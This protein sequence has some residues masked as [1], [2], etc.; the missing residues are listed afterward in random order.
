MKTQKDIKKLQ[1]MGDSKLEINWAQGKLEIQNV[2]LANIVRD[3]KLAFLSFE[4]L[5]FHHVLREL[6]VKVDDLSKEA[7][8]LQRGPFEYYEYF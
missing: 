6:N 7:F 5:S 4:W 3:I 8:Q 2:N 1:V